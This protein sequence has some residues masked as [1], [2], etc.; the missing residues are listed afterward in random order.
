MQT[1]RIQIRIQNFGKWTVRI[2]RHRMQCTVHGAIGLTV[3]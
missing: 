1:L 3:W 2:T